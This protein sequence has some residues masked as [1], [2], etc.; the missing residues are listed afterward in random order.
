M[1]RKI[2]LLGS[3]IT[4]A[5]AS[6][7]QTETIYYREYQM[8]S[9][10]LK[11]NI[12]ISVHLPKGYDISNEHY[13]SHY[14]FDWNLIGKAYTGLID[15]Y[16]QLSEIPEGIIIG[17]GH[18]RKFDNYK[19]SEFIEKELIPFIDSTYRTNSY[20]LL[21][22]HSSAGFH[23]TQIYSD[24]PDLFDSYIVGSPVDIAIPTDKFS[25]NTIMSNIYIAYADNDFPNVI[26]KCKE[27]QTVIQSKSAGKHI[28]VEK[29]SD[30]DHFSS[31]PSV[32]ENSLDF[33]Y[34]HWK[35]ELS[36]ETDKTYPEL[37]EEHYSRLSSEFGYEIL[38]QEKELYRLSYRLLKEDKV[39]K[40]NE[41]LVYSTRLYPNSAF[42]RHLL[43][44]SFVELDDIENAKIEYVKSLELF[45]DNK[46]AKK[47]YDKLISE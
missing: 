7:S 34:Q 12:P 4:I 24:S 40:A 36:V 30:K 20:R 14:L 44:K 41:L 1:I 18:N 13:Q 42:I 22:G 21:A 16:S 15:Y 10:I 3:L 25:E 39:N 33:I 23:A 8:N 45:P 19:Y 6:Y 5:L 35:L 2:L 37:I 28:R 11:K 38:I 32:I 26:S 46:L 47:E 43:A 29:I 27:L 9:E 17:M 31:F